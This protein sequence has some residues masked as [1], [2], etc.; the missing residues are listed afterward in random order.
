M[1]Y[2][3]GPHWDTGQSV[4]PPAGGTTV[5]AAAVRVPVID[6][7]QQIC[8]EAGLRLKRLG[9]FFRRLP[10][11]ADL[12]R[13]NYRIILLGFFLLSIGIVSG[14]VWLSELPQRSS[15]GDVK[16]ILAVVLWLLY[17]ANLHT[18]YMMG[19][20]GARTALFSSLNFVFLAGVIVL[21]G[22]LGTTFHS[23]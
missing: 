14:G 22:L 5:L 16:Q 15:A 23:F 11:L 2:T 7:A 1:D 13:M 12:E 18:R 17:A 6:A 8:L 4:E 20:Q 21:A 3:H 19:W 9:L 10:P